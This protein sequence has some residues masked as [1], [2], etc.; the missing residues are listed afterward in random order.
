MYLIYTV[1]RTALNFGCYNTQATTTMVWTFP[2]IL[3]TWQSWGCHL[4]LLTV[5]EYE[6]MCSEEVGQAYPSAGLGRTC[7]S[8]LILLKQWGL[9]VDKKGTLTWELKQVISFKAIFEFDY[10]FAAL[11]QYEGDSALI[12]AHSAGIY[13][14]LKTPDFFGSYWQ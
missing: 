5:L 3:L 7:V 6:C 9:L 11:V 13:F 1:K 8:K 2:S 10:E 4:I 12:V 14:I